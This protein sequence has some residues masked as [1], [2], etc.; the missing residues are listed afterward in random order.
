[1]ELVKHTAHD[2]ELYTKT[3]SIFFYNYVVKESLEDDSIYEYFSLSDALEYIDSTQK[4]D[5][6][7]VVEEKNIDGVFE[8]KDVIIKK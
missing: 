7:I 4:H 3:P 2:I 5:L 6:I 1:M 8:I